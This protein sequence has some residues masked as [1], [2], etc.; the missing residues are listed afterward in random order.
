MK[1]KK[2]KE[3]RRDRK[4]EIEGTDKVREGRGKT[5][6]IEGESGINV[7]VGGTLVQASSD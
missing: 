4:T 7:L 2:D 3:E 6:K 1:R 5:T